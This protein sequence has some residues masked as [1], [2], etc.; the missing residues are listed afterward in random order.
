MQ[1]NNKL[2]LFILFKQIRSAIHTCIL[3]QPVSQPSNL[4]E[5]AKQST[6]GENSSEPKL[7]N[8][9]LWLRTSMTNMCSRSCGANLKNAKGCKTL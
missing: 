1:I 2:S 3:I 9:F 5:E 8:A 7:L 4:M 6:L